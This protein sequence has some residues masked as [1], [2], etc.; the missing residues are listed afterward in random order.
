MTGHCPIIPDPEKLCRCSI[1]LS[2][3]SKSV[4]PHHRGTEDT[5][6]SKYNCEAGLS[7]L[8]R[9][10]RSPICCPGSHGRL[11]SVHA[12]ASACIRVHPRFHFFSVPSVSLWL[13][14]IRDPPRPGGLPLWHAPC[15]FLAIW[16][17]C[18][19]FAQRRPDSNRGDRTCASRSVGPL[20]CGRHSAKPI[21]IPPPIPRPPPKTSRR[22]TRPVGICCRPGIA[23]GQRRP[24]FG[25]EW[26]DSSPGGG[27]SRNRNACN[28]R[29]SVPRSCQTPS[30]LLWVLCVSVVQPRG[31]QARAWS[32]RRGDAGRAA[33]IGD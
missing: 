8:S 25:P 5:E 11:G 30:D 22:P 20:P 18:M 1:L 26:P 10:L 19:R 9:T 33:C 3:I 14:T 32:R 4:H 23:C 13:S 29:I 16:P 2:K 15:R 7:R 6:K 12:S 28:S 31:P 27:G 17:V 24:S 21:R